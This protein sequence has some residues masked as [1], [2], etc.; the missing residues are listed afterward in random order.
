M[1]KRYLAFDIET[2]K[3][4]PELVTDLL[5]HRPLGICCAAAVAIDRPS[6][7][8]WHGRMASGTPAPRMTPVEMQGL[9]RDLGNLVSEGYTLVTWNGLGFDLDVLAEESGLPRECAELALRHVDMMFH[10]LCTLGHFVGLDSAA[11]AMGLQG[12]VVGTRGHQAPILW[13]AGKYSEV[14]EYNVRDA[15]VTLDLAVTCEGRGTF[16][17]V[18]RKGQLGAMPLP[19]GWFDVERARSLPLPDTSWMADPPRRENLFRWFPRGT[20]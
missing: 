7:N 11:K 1:S 18:T 3:V 2:A 14:I 10:V 19:R 17:W 16:Q 13:A 8:I 5:A 6:A 20:G 9:V 15:R 4:L 12:K